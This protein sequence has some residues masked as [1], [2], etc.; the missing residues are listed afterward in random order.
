M[1]FLTKT[2]EFLDV[3]IPDLLEI[4]VKEMSLDE[5]N[6][7]RKMCETRKNRK[8]CENCKKSRNENW[9]KV[10]KGTLSIAV[11]AFLISKSQKQNEIKP[12]L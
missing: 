8:I 6:P 11:T 7:L 5:T 12:L 4:A 3:F 1:T 10:G 9:M 2:K